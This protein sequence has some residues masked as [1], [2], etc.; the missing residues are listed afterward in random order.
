MEP[1]QKFIQ[2]SSYSTPKT[3]EHRCAPIAA[4]LLPQT[5][6]VV[7]WNVYLQE[8]VGFDVPPLPHTNYLIKNSLANTHNVYIILVV[9]VPVLHHPPCS[10]LRTK[11]VC[12]VH[13]LDVVENIIG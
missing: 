13:A 8:V 1:T 6:L 2:L 4:S 10:D 5:F 11:S 9:V 3:T 12:T 7:F